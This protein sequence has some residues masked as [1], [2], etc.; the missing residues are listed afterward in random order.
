MII[1]YK[2]SVQLPTR[3]EAVLIQ[4]YRAGPKGVTTKRVLHSSLQLLMHSS[5]AGVEFFRPDSHSDGAL[6]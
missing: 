1:N 5:F 4:L 6:D 2:N 3:L